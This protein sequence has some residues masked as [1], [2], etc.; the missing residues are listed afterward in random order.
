MSIGVS[1]AAIGFLRGTRFVY[2]VQ[3][4]W[5]E[6]A[7]ATGF[8]R[9]GRLFNLMAALE[10]FVYRRA[11]H[12]FVVT[13]GARKNLSGKGVPDGKITVASHW[14]NDAEI[15]Q[16]TPADRP[17]VREREGWQDRFVVMFAG[18]LGVLQ[19]LDTVIDA[20]RQL[21]ASS[22]LLVALVGDGSDLPRLKVLARDLDASDRVR[23][24]PR[25]SSDNM[26]RYFAAADALLVH[27][28]SSPLAD[29][30]IPT[31][32]VAYL[33]AGK[34][35]VMATVG[36]SA[37][38]VS[39]AGA[40]LVLPPEDPAALARTLVE[41]STLD[42]VERAQMGQRGRRYFETHFTKD[43]TLPTYITALTRA[44]GSLAPAR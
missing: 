43:A 19:G 3:D 1:A 4:I 44:A 17:A 41:I 34:P 24:V 7:V 21:P 36:A 14:Y 39:T 23:F 20:C 26:A 32:T 35:I 2:D 31:K 25:Q 8:L 11:A 12:L 33:A 6:S 22:R 37:D 27:L 30:T 9:P 29:L 38:I 5:P 13:E 10:G 15:R 18:N 40:G 42:P 28:R 16:V